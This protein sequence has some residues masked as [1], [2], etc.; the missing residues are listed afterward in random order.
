M[1]T[2]WDEADYYI[3]E[4]L[5][6]QG[7]RRSGHLLY[8]YQC[9]GCNRC[10][11]IRIPTNIFVPSKSL[12]RIIKKNR[13]ISVSLLNASYSDER[14]SLYEKYVT[15]RHFESAV[16]DAEMEHRL[17]FLEMTAGLKAR[18]IEYRDQAGILLAEGFVDILPDGI[19]S[20]YFA[21][22]PDASWRSLGRFSINAEI[23]ISKQLQKSFYYLGFW[24]PGSGKMDYKADF[25][26]F[27][28][29]VDDLKPHTADFSRDQLMSLQEKAWRKFSSKKEALSWLEAAGYLD[30]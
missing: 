5:L 4:N 12:S 3:Y 23:Q 10:I 21:F 13:D 16:R 11:S 25:T 22:A 9:P 26:P 2:E 14:F 27:E 30:R 7:W 28:L 6:A 15:V 1:E 8:C 24:V 18:I 20:V 17:A 19:S 29:A